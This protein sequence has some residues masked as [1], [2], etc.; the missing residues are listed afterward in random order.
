MFAV[1]S[2]GKN[3][4]GMAFFE[5]KG[6]FQFDVL[7]DPGFQH[8]CSDIEIFCILSPFEEKKNFEKKI[9]KMT[10]FEI[11]K[12]NLLQQIMFQDKIYLYG[13]VDVFNYIRIH[14]NPENFKNPS[15]EIKTCLFWFHIKKYHNKA[16]WSPFTQY[17][18]TE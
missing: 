1:G 11:T 5:R 13:A 3:A 6:I 10:C 4:K 14:E 12:D 8:L 15:K 17:N 7:L 2:M 18:E 16:P 9:L